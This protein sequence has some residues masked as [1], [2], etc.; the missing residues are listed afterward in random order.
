MTARRRWA[1]FAD[2]RHAFVGE[3]SFPYQRVDTLCG[4]EKQP[5]TPL[6]PGQPSAE[7]ADCDEV[8]RI[9]EGIPLRRQREP[10]S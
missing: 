5:I 6:V 9:A 2:A 4:K 7:C 10:S 8:W 1:E 3:R